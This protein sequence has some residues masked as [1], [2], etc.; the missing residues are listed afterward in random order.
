MGRG[1]TRNRLDFGRDPD[2]F[3][4]NAFIAF[5]TD[6]QI[7]LRL[8]VRRYVK[9]I[10][11]SVCPFYVHCIVVCLSLWRLTNERIQTDYSVVSLGLNRN[12]VVEQKFSSTS[13]W[14]IRVPYSGT[15]T[16]YRLDDRRRLQTTTAVPFRL[17][18]SQEFVVLRSDLLRIHLPVTAD[19]SC[20]PRTTI[21]SAL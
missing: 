13:S 5:L 9:L 15:T 19:S 16:E 17:L 8:L 2:S 11:A 10:L 4:N 1:L 6:V 14:T 12:A 3:A 7:G 21:L 18:H 20:Q